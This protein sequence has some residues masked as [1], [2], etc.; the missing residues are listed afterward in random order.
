MADLGSE[1]RAAQE[2][3]AEWINGFVL[4][5][6]FAWAIE[7]GDEHTKERGRLLQLWV[8]A[9]DKQNPAF[10]REV[11]SLETVNELKRWWSVVKEVWRRFDETG[12]QSVFASSSVVGPQQLS[13]LAPLLAKRLD[14]A[15]VDSLV[16]TTS[17]N[18]LPLL[19]RWSS[20]RVSDDRLCASQRSQ[21]RTSPMP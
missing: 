16:Q 1:K 13:V 18:R 19:A 17:E 20:E 7:S 14:T 15:A 8:E 10:A 3:L 9:Y 6:S 4:Q 5:A 21:S 2:Q 11:F 12:D